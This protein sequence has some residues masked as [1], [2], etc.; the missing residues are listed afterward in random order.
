MEDR[1]ENRPV[2]QGISFWQEVIIKLAFITKKKKKCLYG[3]SYKVLKIVETVKK[4]LDLERTFSL[5]LFFL[6]LV[7][8]RL[9]S[10]S[11]IKFRNKQQTEALLPFLSKPETWGNGQSNGADVGVLKAYS[12]VSGL[13]IM[14]EIS[15]TQQGS[16]VC[17]TGYL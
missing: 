13:L 4:K 15:S 2:L 10:V 14:C 12:Y 1:E 16:K 5:W 6:H 3:L 8:H 9:H 17:S 11:Q 7:Q